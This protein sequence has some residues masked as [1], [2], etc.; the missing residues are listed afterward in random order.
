M[1][2]RASRSLGAPLSARLPGPRSLRDAIAVTIAAQVGVAP[3]LVA[4]FGGVAVVAV[5]AN[6]LA[7]PVA[8]P[9]M[10]WGLPAGV[11]AGLAPSLAPVLHV[12]T[13]LGVRWIALVARVGA[14][15]PLGQVGAVPLMALAAAS[16]AAVAARVGFRRRR[17]EAPP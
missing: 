1:R 5:P 13:R 14:A 16:G 9:L 12:P 15:A 10:V 2:Q 3:I 6:V 17:R 4:A 7:V 11:L 8:G